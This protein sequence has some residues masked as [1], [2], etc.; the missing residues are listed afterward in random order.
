ML[1]QGYDVFGKAYGVMNRNDLHATESIDHQLMR[2]MVLLDADSRGFLYKNPPALPDMREHELY[3]FSQ[4]FRR[5]SDR[6]TI[7][8]ALAFCAELA[9]SYDDVP[10]ETMV[11][12]GTEREIIE[13]GTDWC[14]DLARVGAVLLGCCGIPSRIVHAVNPAA[15]YNGHVLTEAFYEGKFGLCDF[16]RGCRFHHGAPL[17]AWQL[18]TERQHLASFRKDYADTLSAMAISDYNPMDPAN[19]YT[20]SVPNEY[21]L[22]LIGTDHQNKWIMGEDEGEE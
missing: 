15:A 1:K 5:D 17:D 22:T 16:T 4:Q 8:A 6:E 2:E 10:F 11:F 18:L 3:D 20:V 14:A 9:R 12:G 21:T 7:E 13:R 19:D